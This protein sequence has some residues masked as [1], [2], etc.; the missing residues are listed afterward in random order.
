MRVSS[1][2]SRDRLTAK[3]IHTGAFVPETLY[4]PM[5]NRTCLEVIFFRSYYILPNVPEES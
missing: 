4:I 2:K 5:V 3:G 1:P